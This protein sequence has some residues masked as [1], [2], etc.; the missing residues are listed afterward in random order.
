[1]I[2]PGDDILILNI[3][4]D[5]PLNCHIT[6]EKESG[7]VLYSVST[8][9]TDEGTWMTVKNAY[10]DA[11][12]S[13]EWREVRADRVIIG[14][15]KP[16]SL[17]DWLKKGMI[18]FRDEVT[19]TDEQNRTYK[20]KGLSKYKKLELYSSTSNKPIAWFDASKRSVNPQG[21]SFPPVWSQAQLFLDGPAV[22]I[23]DLVVISFLF[24][25]KHQ[26]LDDVNVNDAVSKAA[27]GGPGYAAVMPQ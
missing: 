7:K 9:T 14:D 20:W 11:I 23:K 3:T 10:G 2:L 26:R 13:L 19:L 8:H 17:W 1:M 25:L 5:H 16:V 18:P 12:A 22:A 15:R 27:M 21:S 4:P 24:L 6:E